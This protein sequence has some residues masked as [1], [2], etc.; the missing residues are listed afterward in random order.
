MLPANRRRFLLWAAGA[1]GAF[2]LGAAGWFSQGTRTRSP[3]STMLHAAV[4]NSQAMGSAVSITALH[5]RPEAA[6]RAVRAALAELR[7]VEKRL[8]IYRPDSQLSRLNRRRVLDD[9]HPDLVRVLSASQDMARRTGGAFDVTVQP[10]WTCYAEAARAQAR[11]EAADLRA[12]LDRVDW[13]RI[14]ISPRQIRLHGNGTQVTLN[15]I[16][17]GFAADRVMAVLRR[18]GVEHALV[19]TGELGALGGK[20]DDRAWSVG[21]QHP[22]R[23]DAYLCVAGLQGRCLATSG[24]YATRFGADYDL[25]HLFDPRT[26]HS[27]AAFSSVSVAA[28]T[29]T[30]ADALSTAVFVLGL[31]RGIELIRATPGADALLVLKDGKTLAT[32]GFPRQV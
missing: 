11:P 32:A 2:G 9:P 31:D 3:G 30:Q 24:D 1:G 28:A 18:H 6:Q 8:S 4:E 26:G 25:H 29:A 23:D 12:A 16:A 5:A 14:E 21:I 19:D 13:R 27:P 15:G 10:L 7:L 22:R 20:A 17:Q